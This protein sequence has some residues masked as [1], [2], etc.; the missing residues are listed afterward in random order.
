MPGYSGDGNPQSMK[1]ISMNKKGILI[2]AGILMSATGFSQY[3][4]QRLPVI[5]QPVFR[6][7]TFNIKTY[8]AVPDGRTLNTTAINNAITACSRKGGGGR[9][10]VQVPPRGRWFNTPVCK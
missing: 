4:W 1:I 7:D 9:R 6:K 2:V 8:G 5:K 10:R 3:T